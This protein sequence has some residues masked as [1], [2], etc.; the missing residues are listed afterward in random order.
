MAEDRNKF[1]ND[2]GKAGLILGGVAIAYF[3][4]EILLGKI[5]LGFLGGLIGVV[6]WAGKLILC[7]WLLHSFL[8]KYAA[9]CDNDRS[10]TFRYGMTV[11]F[12][13]ALVYAGFCFAYVQFIQPDFYEQTFQQVA[14]AYSS[15]LTSDQMDQILN[16]ESSMPRL[17]FFAN[18]IWCTLFGTIVSAISSNRICNPGNPF[19]D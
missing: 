9:S 6:L 1:L 15:M 18:L 19:E 5:N 13:S 7:V 11:A 3:L 4:I 12:C 16:M 14:Q 8:K 10:R 17:S 2:S